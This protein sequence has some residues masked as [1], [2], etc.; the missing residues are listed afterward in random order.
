M[1]TVLVVDDSPVDRRLAKAILQQDP[2]LQVVDLPGGAEAVSYLEE[3]PGDL[4]VSDLQMP[5]MDG[6]QLVSI[7]RYRFPR[8]PVVLMTAHGSEEI[9]VG[10]LE[11][12]AA[13]YVAKGRLAQKLRE[14]VSG[15]LA[16]SRSDHSLIQ[17]E[18]SLQEFRVRLKLPNDSRLFPTLVDYLQQRVTVLKGWDEVDRVRIGIAI[19]EAVRN[20]HFHGNLELS[21]EQLES[22]SAHDLVA[23]RLTTPTYAERTIGVLADF[24]QTE[25]RIV[26]TDNGKGFD[27]HGITEAA[28][29][30]LLTSDS[31]R[32]FV[33]MRTF[34]DEVSFNDAGNEVTLV[35]RAASKRT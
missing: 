5:N 17:L 25:L 27:H 14:T 19:E 15:V 23:Q 21:Q 22:D 2:S 6:L 18:E 4:V 13:S 31:G 34:M 12:G 29:S 28:K 32:G 7:L 10:A 33:L 8:L 11:C 9:A 26:V 3:N 24:S 1:P 20:A 35:K 30:N 16:I